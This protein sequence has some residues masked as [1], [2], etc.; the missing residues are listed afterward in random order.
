MGTG[1]RGDGRDSVKKES[2]D[3][4]RDATAEQLAVSW[5]KVLDGDW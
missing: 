2:R 1:P 5:S 3:D 4:G